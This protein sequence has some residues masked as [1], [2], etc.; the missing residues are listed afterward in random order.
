[1]SPRRLPPMVAALALALSGATLAAAVPTPACAQAAASGA[2]S[3]TFAFRDAEAGMV[4]Q[5]VLGAVGVPYAIDPG[6]TGRITFRIEQR[7]TRDQLLAAFEAVLEAHGVALV[8]NGEQLIATPQ[9]KAKSSASVRRRSEAAMGSGF[10]VVAVPLAYG[11]PSEVAKAL[12]AIS[13]ASAVVH[14]DDRLGLL[15]LSGTG[16][17]LKTTLETLKI[18]DQSAFE[19]SKIRWFELSQAQ[20]GTVA[21]EL[22]RIVQGAKLPGVAIVPLRRLNGVIVFGRSGESLTEIARWVARLDTPGK[23]SSSSLW[24]YRPRAASAEALAKTL[25]TVLGFQSA[26]EVTATAPAEGAVAPAAVAGPPVLSST[27]SI[28]Q[29]MGGG[30]EQ[31]RIGV[32]K[33]TNTLIAFASP[34]RWAQMQK[35]LAEIDRTPRQIMIE[36]SILEVTLGKDFAFGVDWSVLSGDVQVSSVNNSAGQVGPTFPGL[37]ITF[38]N[39]DIEAAVS[40]LGSRTYVDVVSAPKIIALDNRTARLQIGDQVP[41]VTRSSQS[42]E[43]P[44]SPL[45]NSVDYRSTGVILT[46]TPRVSGENQLTLEVSQ[47]VSSVSKTS[48]SGI[49]SPTIQQRRFESALVMYDGAV[50]ALGGLISSTHGSGNAGVPGLKDVPGL[51]ALFRSSSR[52]S[53]RTELIVLLT[54]RIIRDRTATEAVMQDLFDDMQELRARGLLPA[55]R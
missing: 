43:G 5:E 37:S 38:L 55:D 13:A 3:Y 26:T 6:V 41:I 7:L 16:Q 45:V 29:S 42:Q 30:D 27:T 11:Q 23:E 14:T 2:D 18:F 44:G 33:D 17:Q 35:I 36:A 46:V 1:M 48:T 39:N 4:I 19:D 8:R 10:E 21:A 20:A 53:T 34:G 50:V 9:A 28:V 31:V 32:D 51:G 49:D 15:V 25:N 40:A 24:V 47:E 54:A 22:E 12:E 52:N